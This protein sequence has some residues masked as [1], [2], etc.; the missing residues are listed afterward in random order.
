MFRH[1]SKVISRNAP[2][3]ALQICRTPRVVNAFVVQSRQ[4]SATSDLANVL[5][6]E[7]LHETNEQDQDQDQDYAEVLHTVKKNFKIVDN[8]GHGS[9]VVTRTYKGESITVTFDCQ[10]EVETDPNALSNQLAEKADQEEDAD[11]DAD[12]TEEGTG[13]GIAFEVSIEKQNGHK[14]VFSCIAGNPMQIQSICSITAEQEKMMEEFSSPYGGPNFHNLDEKLQSSFTEYLAER[15]IND[16]F[17]Y[18]VLS[19]ARFKEEREYML[20]LNNLVDF[21]DSK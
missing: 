13:T 2:L 1:I 14:L 4:F 10:D 21:T 3:V 8:P 17:N 15:K 12:Q 18:F 20:W 11:I 7:I 6:S 19:Y 5:A 16:D 9:V